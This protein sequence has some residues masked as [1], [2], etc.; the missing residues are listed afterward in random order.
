MSNQQLK[1]DE[2]HIKMNTY[3]SPFREDFA[4]IHR[5]ADTFNGHAFLFKVLGLGEICI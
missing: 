2:L 3:L 1:N 4:H 5:T